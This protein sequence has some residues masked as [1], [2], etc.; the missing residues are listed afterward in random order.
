M[1]YM[2]ASYTKLHVFGLFMCTVLGLAIPTLLFSFAVPG[3]LFTTT[4]YD[5]L[6]NKLIQILCGGLYTWIF[7]E[8]K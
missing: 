2:M 8:A 1:K 7:V 4:M 3:K 6:T 5:Y